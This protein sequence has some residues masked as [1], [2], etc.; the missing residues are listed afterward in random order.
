MDDAADKRLMCEVANKLESFKV[1]AH[2]FLVVIV[3][4]IGVGEQRVLL[5]QEE[6]PQQPYERRSLERERASER[7][8]VCVRKCGSLAPLL[9]QETHGTGLIEESK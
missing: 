9:L 7:A 5:F 1:T 8:P 2:H 3:S 6:W 4:F